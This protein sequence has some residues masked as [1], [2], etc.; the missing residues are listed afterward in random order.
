VNKITP[1]TRALIFAGV[2]LLALVLLSASLNSLEMSSGQPLAAPQMAPP[3][4]D[5]NITS[6][7]MRW[8]MAFFR[9]IMIL[10]WIVLPLYII[11]LFISKEERKRFLRNLLFFIPL[12]IALYFVLNRRPGRNSL[13]DSGQGM[14]GNP[15]FDA[16]KTQ[17]P[18]P[19]YTP[20]PNW[21]TTFA[22]VA[23]ALVIALIVLGIFYAL[24][25]QSRNRRQMKEPLKLVEKEAQVA[26]DAITAGGDL[27][28]AVVRCYLQM[29]EALREYRGI[30][31]D[32][33]MTP[34]EFEL[35]LGRRGMPGEPI[36]QL[37]RL[38]EE[39]RY[40][41]LKPARKDEQVAIASLSAIISACQRASERQG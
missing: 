10:G 21:V 29:I 35:I 26:L 28:E 3:L 33:D 8:V 16:A 30:N 31:R 18:L 11:M 23:I 39:V 7:G 12:L 2:T 19:E 9:L 17:V 15:G 38:F 14:L 13:K 36:H 27:R 25:R 41:T 5:P 6:E 4:Y 40:G 24:W 22:T 34:H 32:Q 1:R 20:P 37:T